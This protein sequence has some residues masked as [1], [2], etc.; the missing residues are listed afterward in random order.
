[1]LV[2]PDLPYVDSKEVQKLKPDLKEKVHSILAHYC[3]TPQSP[4]L[5]GNERVS[6]AHLKQG[7]LV[8][9]RY[10][11]Q[12]HGNTGDGNGVAAGILDS[13]SPAIT[14][15]AS[16]NSR[17]RPTDAKPLREDL[18]RTVR[19]GIRGTSMP[20]FNLLPPEDQEAVVDYVLTL[21]RRGELESQL[22][23][24]AFLN[25]AIDSARVPEMVTGILNRWKQAQSQVVYPSTPMPEFTAANHRQ[26][27][28]R[29]S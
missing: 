12:C 7:A 29:R 24:E 22:A 17:P 28:K 14:G 5:L 4:K 1:M 8:Y 13:R 27:A 9:S 10:C 6:P 21:T 2:K 15:W 25:E 11:I 20:S 18:L 3:G 16:L 19:R 26:G 23:E